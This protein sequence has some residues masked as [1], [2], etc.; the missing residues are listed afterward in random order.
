MW[1]GGPRLIDRSIDD[2]DED[3]DC[4]NCLVYVALE[5]E[6][7]VCLGNTKAFIVASS[8]AVVAKFNPPKADRRTAV[9][10]QQSRI[11]AAWL[12]PYSVIVYL[13]IM[14]GVLVLVVLVI[15][16]GVCCGVRLATSCVNSVRC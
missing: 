14:Y 9:R 16:Q 15:P 12:S 10:R 6:L 11:S 3:D 5:G 4:L 7:Y 8:I 13:L 2:E 1:R